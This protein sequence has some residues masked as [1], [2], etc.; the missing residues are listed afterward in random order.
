IRLRLSNSTPA[1]VTTP[2]GTKVAQPMTSGTLV[3]VLKFHRNAC[4]GDR[5]DGEITDPQQLSQCRT[6]V[7]EIVVSDPLKVPEQATIPLSDPSLASQGLTFKFSTALPINAWDVVLQ[8]VYRGQLGSESD[9][10]VI[11]SRDISEPTFITTF[12][13]TDKL[14]IAGTCYDPATVAATD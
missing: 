9:A 5:L 1:I 7:E 11:A 6:P 10:V 12:N 4:Y 14:L 2:D 8:V 3:A 13:D